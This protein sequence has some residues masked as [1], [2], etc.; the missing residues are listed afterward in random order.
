MFQNYGSFTLHS[1]ISCWID[2]V[3]W[4]SSLIKALR[5]R[6]SLDWLWSTLT[7][8]LNLHCGIVNVSPCLLIVTS[9]TQRKWRQC[10]LHIS[11]VLCQISSIPEAPW[12]L[13]HAKPCS[14]SEQRIIVVCCGNSRINLLVRKTGTLISFNNGL[15]HLMHGIYSSWVQQAWKPC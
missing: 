11:V 2:L 9:L 10:S 3:Q 7:I 13:M 8:P 12:G 15:P 1:P 6:N 5:M 4:T 14:S